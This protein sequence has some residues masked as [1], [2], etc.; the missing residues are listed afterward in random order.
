MTPDYRAI[1]EK[2]KEME[3]LGDEFQTMYRDLS[4]DDR[5]RFD[6]NR[7]F[8]LHSSRMKEGRIAHQAS[9]LAGDIRHL[10]VAASAFETAMDI[11][12]AARFS[13]HGDKSGTGTYLRQAKKVVQEL[14]KE[15]KELREED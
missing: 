12:E 7:T 3:Q 9:A 1:K 10:H 2:I 15:I 4:E 11:A 14:V 6:R 13:A 8:Y 5:E